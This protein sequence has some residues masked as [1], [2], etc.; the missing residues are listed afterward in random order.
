M[1]NFGIPFINNFVK[2]RNKIFP[3]SKGLGKIMFI[4]HIKINFQYEFLKK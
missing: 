2:F 1:L 4:I 3:S